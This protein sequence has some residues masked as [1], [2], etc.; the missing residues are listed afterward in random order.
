MLISNLEMDIAD[1]VPDLVKILVASDGSEFIRLFAYFE[2]L[3]AS[4][5]R[6]QQK[7]VV[8]TNTAMSFMSQKNLP[9][10]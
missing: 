1:V 4:A 3:I 10:V 8:F 6:L 9:D 5:I 2:I 7:F